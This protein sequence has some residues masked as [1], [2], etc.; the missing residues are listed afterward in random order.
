MYSYCYPEQILAN[1]VSLFYSML[2]SKY[3]KYVSFNGKQF[4]NKEEMEK[5]VIRSYDMHDIHPAPPPPPTLLGI[6]FC[7][8]F[9]AMQLRRWKKF[10]HANPDDLK[11]IPR[12][13][14]STAAAA[15]DSLSSVSI[16]LGFSPKI[17]I[18]LIIGEH[19]TTV[20]I[21]PP[22]SN[23]IFYS[24]SVVTT[25]QEQECVRALPSLGSLCSNNII[26][27]WKFDFHIKSSVAVVNWEREGLR[28][29]SK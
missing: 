15:I 29:W 14:N 2:F 22:G 1:N 27:E 26:A 7:S 9:I 5:F 25:E 11:T 16:H 13:L 3:W 6:S 18:K 21:V 17:K 10:H 19:K 12:L 23:C 28:G 24:F 20:F 8:T 4:N